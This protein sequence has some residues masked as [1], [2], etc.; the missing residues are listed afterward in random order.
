MSFPVSEPDKWQIAG[1]NRLLAHI[2]RQLQANSSAFGPVI[3]G[4]PSRPSREQREATRILVG[5][6][7]AWSQDMRE[8]KVDASTGEVI[9]PTMEEQHRTWAEC[10]ER[11]EAEIAHALT[12]QEQAA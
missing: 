7:N 8:W 4:L 12:P 6:K 1:N 10:I 9:A 2:M 3:Y 11:A 5:Y